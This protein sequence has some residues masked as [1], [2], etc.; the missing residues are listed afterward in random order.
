MLSFFGIRQRIFFGFERVL[1]RERVENALLVFFS[2]LFLFFLL[3][4]QRRAT[5]SNHIYCW[6]WRSRAFLAEINQLKHVCS[7]WSAEIWVWRLGGEISLNRKKRRGISPRIWLNRR[8][9]TV[10][11]RQTVEDG[12][13]LVPCSAS[14]IPKTNHHAATSIK[15][16][17]NVSVSLP[18]SF[19]LCNSVQLKK[20][21]W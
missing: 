20:R 7:P 10:A 2:V 4:H 9:D 3:S 19:A 15:T 16:I 1:E 12:Q 14:H 17:T 18:L 13:C 8:L 11:G 5:T 21:A 6:P